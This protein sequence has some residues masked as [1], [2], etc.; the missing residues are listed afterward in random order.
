VAYPQAAANRRGSGPENVI[1]AGHPCW[2]GKPPSLQNR[3]LFNFFYNRLLAQ[4]IVINFFVLLPAWKTRR[5][6]CRAGLAFFPSSPGFLGLP[7][8]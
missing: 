4:K 3:Q 5:A 8:R 6:V 7:K 2:R 1:E